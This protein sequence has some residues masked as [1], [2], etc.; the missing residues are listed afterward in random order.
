[1]EEVVQSRFERVA[2]VA[3]SEVRGGNEREVRITVDPYKAAGVGID[4]VAAAA[5]VGNNDDVSGGT[6]DVGKR[7]YVIRYTGALE[8]ADLNN[9]ILEWRDGQAIY[10]RDIATVKVQPAD[11][12]NFV[13]TRGEPAIAVN[14][15]RESGVNVL[16]V[17]ADLQQAM[18]ELQ[19]GPLKRAKLNIDQVYDETDY[20]NSAI[21]L[22]INNLGFGILLAV[23]VLWWR[24]FCWNSLSNFRRVNPV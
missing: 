9:L 12:D 16:D 17:M 3:L 5:I 21:Q 18:Q 10:L 1:M 13:I 4:L 14:A 23:L 11:K 2:G 6:S 8:P 15:Y 24:D 22:L 19:A 20:I 7:Q